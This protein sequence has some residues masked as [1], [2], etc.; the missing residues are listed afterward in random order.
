MKLKTYVITIS[1]KFPGYHPRKGDP[2]YF[3]SGIVSRRKKHT[4]R[5]N[6]ALWK[7][8]FDEIAA[9]RAKLSLR[10]WIGKPYCSKQFI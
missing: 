9:G 6:Y 7:K 10:E 4:I 1:K 8:R 5:G 3:S 2:T